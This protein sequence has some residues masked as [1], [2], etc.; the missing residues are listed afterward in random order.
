MRLSSTG[1]NEEIA[2]IEKQV[3]S[4]KAAYSP[5]DVGANGL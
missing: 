1:F 2:R 3:C 5:A 4:M